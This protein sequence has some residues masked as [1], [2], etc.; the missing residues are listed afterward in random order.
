MSPHDA[1]VRPFFTALRDRWWI[2]ALCAITAAGLTFAI[3]KRQPGQFE[4]G[5]LLGLKNQYLDR[6]LFEL[7]AANKTTEETLAQQPGQLDTQEAVIELTKR[8]GRQPATDA[9]EIMGNTSVALD[10]R[11]FLPVVNGRDEDAERA[12][13]MANEFAKVIVDLRA[14]DDR[15]RIKRAL[16]ATQDELD[17]VTKER[18]AL[19]G[20]SSL[21]QR[22]TQREVS[23]L[24]GRRLRLE[25][26]L[27]FRPKTVSI[28]KWA[29]VPTARTRPPAMN[30]AIFAGVFGVMMGCALL[31]WREARD[32][33]P[34]PAEVLQDLRAAI[35]T[36]LPRTSL[37]P[38]ARKHGPRTQEFAALDAVRRVVQAD[39]PHSVVAVTEAVTIGRA[40][41]L[42]RLLAETA[43]MSGSRTLLATN[44]PYVDEAE[45][46]GLKVTRYPIE[47]G[48][49]ARVWL[50]ERRAAYDLVVIDLPSPVGS[51]AGLELASL[52][53]RVIAVWLPDSIDRRQLAR[54]GRT[55]SRADVQLAG[56]VRVGG[57][58]A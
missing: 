42:A 57:Q 4:A 31:G 2:V 21:V 47:V 1:Q 40:S 10:K 6:D 11:Y 9:R 27:Q 38:G 35:I 5:T 23:R 20:E 22:E 28:V 46:D 32:R 16:A 34:R 3:V 48:E 26:M 56:V 51:A 33:R 43:A 7:S 41:A 44:D 49:T 53:D 45:L 58:A 13:L 14:E 55:L 12:A 29:Q 39:R 19:I 37:L 54:F 18:I 30:M 24:T 36:D 15:K 17:R 25:L 52:A 8:L 50:D